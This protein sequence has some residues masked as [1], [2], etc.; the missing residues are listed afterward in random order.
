MNQQINDLRSLSGDE[1]SQRLKQLSN[2]KNSAAYAEM[3]KQKTKLARELQVMRTTLKDKNPDVLAKQ[4]ELDQVNGQLKE[5]LEDWNASVAKMTKA[6]GSRVDLRVSSI[7]IE[8]QR[9]E[10]ELTRQRAMLASADGQL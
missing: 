2:P 1:E 4:T 8:K 5:M 9:A 10:G 6:S 7:E 3:L